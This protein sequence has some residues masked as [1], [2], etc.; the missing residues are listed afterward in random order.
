MN[1]LDEQLI[2]DY[3]KGDEA[4]F[5]LLVQNYLKPIYSF[6]YR[7][8][9]NVHD[10]D[11]ITQDVFVKVWRNLKKPVLSLSKGFNP[12]KG[13]FKTWIFAIAKNTAID[14]LKKKKTIPFSEFENDKGEN[15]ITETLV[16]PSPLPN[17]LLERVSVAQMLTS[18]MKKLSPKYEIILSLRY[19]NHFIFREI[20]E[21]LGEPLHTIKSRHRRALIML[22]KLLTD[23]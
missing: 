2:E 1:R 3:F 23:S 4:S 21:S 20:A 16:D 8:V 13:S 5:E 19:N 14:H 11:D 10:A 18:A 12:K 17:E 6:V 22:K 7:Y 9:D 15:M